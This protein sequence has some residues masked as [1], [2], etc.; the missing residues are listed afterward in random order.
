MS[1]GERGSVR[2]TAIFFGF[3]SLLVPLFPVLHGRLPVP[4]TADPAMIPGAPRAPGNSQLSDVVTQFLPWTRAVAEA[5]RAG[6]MPFRFASNG[7]GTALWGNM[8]AQAA[9]PTTL[10]AVLLPWPWALAFVAAAKLLA[11]QWGAY[12]LLRRH[13]LSRAAATFGGLAFA[14]SVYFGALLFFPQTYPLALLPWC[15]LALDLAARGE[16]GA[17]PAVFLSVFLLLLGGHAEGEFY[18]ALAGVLAL[19]AGLATAPAAARARRLGL[20]AAASLLA[21]GLAAAYLVPVA[22]TILASERGAMGRAVDHFA[23]PPLRAAE[24]FRPAPWWRG[25]AFFVVPEAQGN[26]RD[27]DTIGAGSMAARAG[28]YLGILT[29]GL[30]AG[31]FLSRHASRAVRWAR[32]A[33]LAYGLF[34]FYL[35]LRLLLFRVPGIR[36]AVARVS[37]NQSVTVITLAIAYLAATQLDRLRSDARTRRIQGWLFAALSLP[38]LA[39]GLR[40]RLVHPELL[41][42]WRAGTFVL[43]LALLAAAVLLLRRRRFEWRAFALFVLAGTAV[44]LSRIAARFDPG[45]VSSELYPVTPAVG[46]LREGSRG[47]RFATTGVALTGMA[48][49]FGLED[50]RV[51]DPSAPAEYEAVLQATLGYTGP[52]E[53]YQR[54]TRWNEPFLASLGVSAVLDPV[55]Q[56]VSVLG[57]AARARLPDRLIGLPN[58]TA[59]LAAMGEAAEFRRSA[60]HVGASEEF[61]G[62]SSVGPE[63]WVSPELVRLRVRASAPRL[64]VLAETNDGGWRAE[65]NGRPLPVSVVDGIFL[66]VRV[67]PGDTLV[68][69]RYAPP[70]F[71]EGLAISGATAGILAALAAG[72]ALRRRRRSSLAGAARE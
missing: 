69:C 61:S 9:A 31:C 54:I 67:P 71:R 46:A 66:G 38:V 30:A 24:W 51:H 63:T 59:L 41:T 29:L 53:Y 47:S 44:D 68:E 64:L 15:L 72:A 4:G 36:L 25:T 52:G 21:A 7:C 18:V 5:Y 12:F 39:L 22:R 37:P 33:I 1:P 3:F 27:G 16:R 17:F 42:A 70:G 35:P 6:R 14:L 34:I 60:Y 45:T 11:A 28:G 8:Q 40:F 23:P 19:I 20:A 55:T 50:A 26:P 65:G 43:P 58:R 13:G 10:L 56:R 32:R 62:P 57:S 2:A 48:S 49:M